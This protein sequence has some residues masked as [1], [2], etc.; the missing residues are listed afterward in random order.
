MFKNLKTSIKF[1]GFDCPIIFENRCKEHWD[2]N[3]KDYINRIEKLQLKFKK[4]INVKQPY[5][6]HS[7]LIDYD[8]I[9]DRLLRLC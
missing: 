6:P 1:F 9:Y 4:P 7:F 3:K 8:S 2:K 5:Y